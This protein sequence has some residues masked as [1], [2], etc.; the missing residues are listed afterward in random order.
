MREACIYIEAEVDRR[1][2]LLT[3]DEFHVLECG[4]SEVPRWLFTV[5][6]GLNVVPLDF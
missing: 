6:K 3:F 1:A 5:A 4:P 2:G